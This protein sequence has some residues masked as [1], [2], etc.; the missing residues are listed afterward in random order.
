M[1][2]TPAPRAFVPVMSYALVALNLLAAFFVVT[3]ALPETGLGALLFLGVLALLSVAVTRPAVQARLADWLANRWLL[4]AS[5]GWVIFT[6]IVLDKFVSQ[7]AT[8]HLWSIIRTW[9][10]T[11]YLWGLAFWWLAYTRRTATA[12]PLRKKHWNWLILACIGVSVASLALMV[13]RPRN[14]DM[15]SRI[16][17]RAAYPITPLIEVMSDQNSDAADFYV[18]HTRDFPFDLRLVTPVLHRPT[19]YVVTSQICLVLD[20]GVMGYAD[21]GTKCSTEDIA[22]LSYFVMNTLMFIVSTLIFYELVA[23]YLDHRGISLYASFLFVVCPLQ[24]WFLTIASTDYGD[25]LII[26]FGLWVLHQIYSL[27][28]IRLIDSVYF[29][30][31][32][33][34]L[35]LLKLLALHFILAVLLVL[36]AGRLRQITIMI[37]TAFVVFAFYRVLIESFGVPFV[38]IEAQGWNVFAWVGNVFLA[39]TPYEQM[40]YLAIWFARTFG[41]SVMMFGALLVGI[42]ALTM[43]PDIPKKVIGLFWL[44]LISSV[45][46]SFA[47][48]F[49][50]TI[51]VVGLAPFVYGGVALLVFTLRTP[52]AK[53]PRYAKLLF[54]AALMLPLL[55]NILLWGTWTFRHD[56][57]YNFWQ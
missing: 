13:G 14:L 30:I 23:Y 10:A 1:D 36:I 37:A 56:M 22:A 50:Y 9:Q 45:M 12:V 47:F 32:M 3:A 40:R 54:Y 8:P 18:P 2:A 33:G 20:I 25:T 57:Y 4:V 34:I 27:N 48:S 55:H 26:F 24:V 16:Y 44:S 39:A 35:L 28:R 19:A 49:S 21:P 42:P 15:L 7:P 41:Q 11:V 38:V 31:L 43:L 5:F 17:S 51:H 46:W 6:T 52:F 53:Y 29:G